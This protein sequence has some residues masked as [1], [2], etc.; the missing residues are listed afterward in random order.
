[1]SQL[2]KLRSGLNRLRR[3]RQTLR[4]LTGYSAML[5]ALVWTLLA[6]FLADWLFLMDAT[7]RMVSLA[8][9]GVALLWAFFKYTTPFLGVREDTTEMALLVERNQDI[10]SDI[11]AAIQFEDDT[12]ARWGS[13]QLAD[14]VVGYVADF[15]TRLNVFHG[16][17]YQQVTRRLLVTVVSLVVVGVGVGAAPDFTQVFFDRMLMGDTHYPTKTQIQ[18]VT[19]AGVTV[20][21][22]GS[23]NV[24]VPFGKP[25]KFEV[26]CAGEL[27]DSGLAKLVNRKNGIQTEVEL[28]ADVAPEAG[29]QTYIGELPRLVDSVDYQLF[30]G[31][32][33]TDP[34]I[35]NAIPLPVVDFKLTTTPPSYAAHVRSDSAQDQSGLRQIAVIEGSKV[36]LALTCNNKMLKR[37]WLTIDEKEI[38]L[39]KSDDSGREWQLEDLES[40]LANVTEPVRFAIQV[41]DEDGLS[42]VKPINGY[43]R[44][45]AD[46]PPRVF[47]MRTVK[48]PSIMP[49]A[50]PRFGYG[51]RDDY[52]IAKLLLHVEVFRADPKK[53]SAVGD[54]K[55]IEV[56]SN[57]AGQ[58]PRLSYNSSDYRLPL[59]QFGLEKGDELKLEFEAFDYRGNGE[60]KSNRSEALV[61]QVTDA[62]GLLLALS[63]ADE[64]SAEQM[65]AIIERELSIG[66]D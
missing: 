55:T 26:V 29:K 6:V 18:T 7:Q 19:V 60:S 23:T 20:E 32:A 33:Y 49:N 56:V 28:T 21:S 63:Q 39:A 2:K 14:A 30:L 15:S 37:A 66:R 43:V 48:N 24:R 10:D 12:S 3:R 61:L 52:G 1:M 44:L 35:V 38:E 36:D 41:E 5:V 64:L 22:D 34:L 17:D 50:E 59:E 40:P 13:R 46:R 8:I 53:A 31:D 16:M 11:V 25:V 58:L 27:P 42:M 65:D 57:Q 45:K 62:Q 54:H 9:G 51:A 4:W 47:A